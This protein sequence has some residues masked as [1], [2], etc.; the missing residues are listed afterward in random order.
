MSPASGLPQ[1]KLTC[2]QR[3]SIPTDLQNGGYQDDLVKSLRKA[4]NISNKV[5]KSQAE[6]E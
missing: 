6:V 2:I 1:L 5:D 3:T 4:G